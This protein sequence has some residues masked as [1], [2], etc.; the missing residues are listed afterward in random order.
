MRFSVVQAARLEV[1]SVLAR[2]GAR[3]MNADQQRFM[4]I[5]PKL[6]RR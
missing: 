2:L 5:V 6:L 1:P 3:A 4:P